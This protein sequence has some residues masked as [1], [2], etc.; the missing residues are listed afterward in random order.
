MRELTL[1]MCPACD[2]VYAKPSAYRNG[3]DLRCTSVTSLYTD[4]DSTTDLNRCNAFLRPLEP[5]NTFTSGDYVPEQV[6]VHVR[7]VGSFGK[8]LHQRSKGIRECPL[9]S[10][11]YLRVYGAQMKR[12]EMEEWEHYAS[13]KQL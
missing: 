10:A 12:A 13:G 11:A 1:W 2:A 3:T 8:C 9:C 6:D 5:A 4:Q 7:N